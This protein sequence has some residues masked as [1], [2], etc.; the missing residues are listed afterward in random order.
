MAPDCKVITA[1]LLLEARP[2]TDLY[3]QASIH[4]HNGRVVNYR[5]DSVSASDH[6]V[7]LRPLQ[8]VTCRVL[9]VVSVELRAGEAVLIVGFLGLESEKGPSA[10]PA[11]VLNTDLT[12]DGYLLAG[13]SVWGT[14]GSTILNTAG[15]VVG[16]VVSSDGELD[17]YGEWIG[18]SSL[19]RAVDVVEDLNLP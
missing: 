4:F 11:H 9:E 1:R 2:S 13:L 7:I 12:S 5:L 3:D 16:M 17:Q 14:P 8:S 15:E 6:L 10:I 18:Y 19:T